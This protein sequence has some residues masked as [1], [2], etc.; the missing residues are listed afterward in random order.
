MK[1]NCLT[2]YMAVQDKHDLL[3]VTALSKFTPITL[4]SLSKFTPIIYLPRWALEFAILFYKSRG[5]A[6]EGEENSPSA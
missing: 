2:S 4:F 3:F 5:G 1:F 6:M